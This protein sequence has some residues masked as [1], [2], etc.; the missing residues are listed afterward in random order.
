MLV[1]VRLSVVCGVSD[2]PLSVLEGSAHP[3]HRHVADRTSFVS[4]TMSG[5]LRGIKV[6]QHN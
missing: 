1:L 2:R 3:G 4:C 6:Y 5:R